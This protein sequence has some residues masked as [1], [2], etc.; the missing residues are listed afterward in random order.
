MRVPQV[1]DT[2][3]SHQFGGIYAEFSFLQIE[4]KKYQ[5]QTYK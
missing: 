5:R 2:N 4:C 1:S 3:S